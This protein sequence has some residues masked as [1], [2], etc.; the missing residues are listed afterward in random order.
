MKKREMI[1]GVLGF[2]AGIG[3]GMIVTN[4]VRSTTPV[5]A[6]KIYKGFVLLGGY[7]LG[8]MASDNAEEWMGKQVD[9][10]ADGWD[11]I[12]GAVKEAKEEIK[13]HN[14]TNV[15]NNHKE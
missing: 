13:V 11:K 9:A 4:I 7:A 10:L 14:I 1:K 5:G 15:D 3:S 6:G 2:G 8:G 12:R